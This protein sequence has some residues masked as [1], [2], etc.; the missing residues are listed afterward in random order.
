MEHN[1]VLIAISLRCDLVKVPEKTS[2]LVNTGASRVVL[3]LFV[4]FGYGSQ[5]F[6]IFFPSSSLLITSKAH[7]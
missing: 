3:G 2:S 5:S 1:R 6:W 4:V 7:N